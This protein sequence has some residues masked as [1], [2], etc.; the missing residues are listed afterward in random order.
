MRMPFG[1]YYGCEVA[2]LPD[3]YLAWLATEADI[4]NDALAAAIDD[5]L[6]RRRAGRS[7][8]GGQYSPPR[9]TPADDCVETAREI[10]RAG[11]R[12]LALKH[13]PDAG[14]AGDEMKKINAAADWM[15]QQLG[16]SK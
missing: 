2:S 11:R 8:G 9:G 15:L 16:V 14:G 4:W 10:V 6:E 5:E 7:Y 12:S 13:H 3:D 1:K